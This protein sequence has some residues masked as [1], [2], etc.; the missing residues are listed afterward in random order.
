MMKHSCLLLAIKDW[1]YQ[2]QKASQKERDVNALLQYLNMRIRSLID[3]A[4]VMYGS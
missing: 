4:G 2:E 1:T 3:L